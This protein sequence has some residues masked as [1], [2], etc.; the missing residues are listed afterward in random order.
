MSKGIVVLAQNNT[1]DDYVLQACLLAMS[2]QTYNDTK[3]S[4]I[5]NDTVPNNYISLFDEIIPTV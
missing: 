1:N 2:L 4:L 3:I 5:T